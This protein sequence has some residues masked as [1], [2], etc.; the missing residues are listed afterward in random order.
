[1]GK[2]FKSYYEKTLSY[3][4]NWY[5]TMDYAPPAIVLLYDDNQGY[6]IGYM[7]GEL[8]AGVEAMTEID[9]LAEILVAQD[10]DG[11]YFGD[12]LLHRWDVGL[13]V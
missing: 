3:S 1:M 5:G 6:C 4:P 13:D 8:P 10:I 2:Y 12:K 11:V 9:A 7:D